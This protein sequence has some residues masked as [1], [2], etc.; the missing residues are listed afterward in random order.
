MRDQW[1]ALRAP[2]RGALNVGTVKAAAAKGSKSGSI[3]CFIISC[4]KQEDAVSSA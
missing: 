3:A 2:I 1:T 4:P